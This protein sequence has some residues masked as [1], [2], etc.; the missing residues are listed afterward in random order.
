[1]ESNDANDMQALL[2]VETALFSFGE[3]VKVVEVETL[4]MNCL[5]SYFTMDDG[6]IFT[7]FRPESAY[8]SCRLIYLI[9]GVTAFTMDSHSPF[10]AGGDLERP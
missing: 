3:L 4:S 9:S 7:I 5:R 1:M 2:G 10:S 8:Q 6:M